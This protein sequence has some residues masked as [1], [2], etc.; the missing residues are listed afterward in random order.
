MQRVTFYYAIK[1]KKTARFALGLMSSPTFKE[2][3]EIKRE[4]ILLKGM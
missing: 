1:Q 3:V 4:I 2:M